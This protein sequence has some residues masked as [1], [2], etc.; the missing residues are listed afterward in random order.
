MKIKI[1]YSWQATTEGKYNRFFIKKAIEEAIKSIYK[2]PDFMDIE[3]ELLEGTSGSSGSVSPAHEILD[4]RIPNCDIF[5]SDLTLTNTPPSDVRKEP[6]FA[7]F[8]KYLKL[9]PNPN[10]LL[11][12]GIAYNEIGV[13]NII[14]VINEEYG[15]LKEVGIELP[16]DIKHLRFPISYSYNALDTN[17]NIILEK[18]VKS[19]IEAITTTTIFTLKTR[20]NKYR[21]F[22]SWYEWAEVWRPFNKYHKNELISNL[23]STIQN[24]ITIENNLRLIGLSGMGKSRILLETFRPI[25][26]DND[27][28]KL[29]SRILYYDFQEKPELDLTKYILELQDNNED[30]ILILDNCR[31]D[32]HINLLN[33]LNKEN[34]KIFLISIN[35]N[36]EEL[37]LYKRPDIPVLLMDQKK[38]ND[39]VNEII[40]EDFSHFNEDVKKRI[41]EFSQGIPLM[42]T[43]LSEG[44]KADN[45]KFGKIENKELIDKLLGEKGNNDIDRNILRSCSLFNYIGFED[46]H[47]KQ[48]EY[49][50]VNKNI[51]SVDIQNDDVLINRFTETCNHYLNRQI[52]Q[53][54]GHYISMRPLP[55]AM[56]LAGEWLETCTTP[57]MTNI[58]D[59]LTNIQE[60]EHKTNIVESFAKQMKY[61]NFNPKAAEI[62]SGL[63]SVGGPFHDAKVLNSELGSRLFRSFVEVNPIT[64]SNT[65][66]AIFG[67]MS[68][69]EL[70]NI[71]E[72]RRNI[73]W[74]LEKLCFDKR[75]FDKSAKTLFLF[76]LAENESW[77]NNATG[78]FIHLFKILLPGTE[79]DLDQRFSILKWCLDRKDQYSKDLTFKSIKAAL[80]T[81]HFS[82][83]MG[84]ESQGFKKL[85]DYHP[86]Y[87]EIDKYWKNILEL[88]TTQITDTEFSE[89]SIE[90]ILGAARSFARY[91]K[92]E[93]IKDYL[94][95]IF[96]LKNWDYDIGL[97]ALKQVKKYDKDFLSETE[98]E[99]INKYIT[100]LSKD[101]FKFRFTKGI[102]YLHLDLED[103]SYDKEIEYFNNLA[104]EFIENKYP[105]DEYFPILFSSRPNFTF[106]FGKKLFEVLKG[107]DN[108]IELFLNLA[109]LNLEKI[110]SENRNYVLLAGFLDQIDNENKKIT[111]KKLFENVKLQDSLFY[112]LSVDNS[113]IEYFS[114]LFNLIDNGESI[115]KLY[116]NNFFQSLSKANYKQIEDFFEEILKRDQ[117]KGLVFIFENIFNLTYNNLII[118]E[119]KTYAKTLFSRFPNML[120]FSEYKISHLIISILNDEKE[121]EFAKFINNTIVKN[122]TWQNSHRIDNEIEKIYEILILKYFDQ[123]WNDLSTYLVSNDEEYIRFFGLKNVLGSHIGSSYRRG[124]GLLFKGDIEK[125]FKWAEELPDT[126][127]E[128]LAQLVPIYAEENTKYNE[129]NPIAIRLLDT[130]GAN[131]NVISSFSA[132][133]GTYSWVG[134]TVPLLEGKKQIFMTLS[135]H[136]ISKVRE[137]AM[138]RLELIDKEI[139]IERKRNEEMYL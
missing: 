82:R 57:K 138:S 104:E 23:I 17:K 1:F 46:D 42:A 107:E 54:T 3:Y 41:S 137:W 102:E 10:V 109:I 36:P 139:D 12:Y 78:E 24:S 20:K 37:E 126:A 73:I 59:Y 84:A 32:K 45:S 91:G 123:I 80:D 99:L 133:M 6:N 125:I 122:I 33:Y 76:A 62:V 29:T 27:S 100:N 127:P 58:I 38:L 53:K 97:K 114:Y 132:N 69:V 134:S 86:T 66:W 7:E 135:D 35:S 70:Q 5:I 75:T 21:P 88:L 39:I 90:I 108:C 14:A 74:S 94:K 43:L 89:K 56:Y 81:S 72:G 136:K 98:L 18:L 34:N 25:D 4:K 30:K 55:L 67:Q 128:R 120:D 124:E 26:G 79:A 48:L 101:D 95:I 49:I 44:V 106:A 11:E 22:I 96:E 50:A 47:R 85:Q 2:L 64:T 113:G 119:I 16:F 77:S 117:E 9:S 118:Y 130:F 68:I 115:Q 52:F 31:I 19:L 103:F 105:W 63:T 116:N 51:T 65:L 112:L 111:Y 87:E 131:K 83:F 13:E 110:S 8:L 129:L 60:P 93:L 92:F 71:E 121:D 15:S 40:E 61:L 28:I